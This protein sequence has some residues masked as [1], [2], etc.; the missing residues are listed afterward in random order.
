MP[1]QCRLIQAPV[2]AAGLLPKLHL[3]R[4]TP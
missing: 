1:A 3:N 4:H 2:L